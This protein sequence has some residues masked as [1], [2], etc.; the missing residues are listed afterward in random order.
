M[1]YKRLPS[2][3]RRAGWW[4]RELRREGDIALY[5]QSSNSNFEVCSG[6]VV[7]LIRRKKR[8]LFPDGSVSP[9]QELF[10]APSKFGVTGFFYM[11]RAGGGL[12]LAQEK[13]HQLL[14]RKGP[15]PGN[16]GP[17]R[18]PDRKQGQGERKA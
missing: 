18:H 4:Y 12:K 8:G 14:A 16:V 13:F 6:I 1:K 7:A 5:E 10:P 9:A 17:I 15:Q 3:F 2:E 11:C